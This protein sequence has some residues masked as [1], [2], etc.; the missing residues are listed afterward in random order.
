MTKTITDFSGYV[1]PALVSTAQIIHDAI[2]AAA[3]KFEKLPFTMAD[4]QLQITGCDN[5]YTKKASRATADINAFNV[6]RATLEGSCSQLGSY[7]NTVAQGDNTT[8][9]ASGIPS[10]E[11][12]NPADYS[13]PAAPTNVV[14]RQGDV[15]GEVIARYRPSRS[16]S[17]NEVQTCTADPTV[18]ANWTSYGIFSGGKAVLDGFTP[19]TALYVRIRTAGLRG[20]MGDWT[21]PAKVI[22]I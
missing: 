6:A 3:A 18:E 21:N 2:V 12:G 15:S 1:G 5:A 4:F 9:I 14:V 16:P 19:A 13:A 20:V 11:T 7:V 22:V 8:I 10:Y 17:M